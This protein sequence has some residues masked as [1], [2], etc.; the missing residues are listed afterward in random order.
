MTWNPDSMLANADW[1]KR[2]ADFFPTVF[3][4]RTKHMGPGDHPSGSPQDVHGGGGGNET[5]AELIDRELNRIERQKP[6]K[7]I[8]DTWIEMS[9]DQDALDLPGSMPKVSL[10]NNPNVQLDIDIGYLRPG[11]IGTLKA[12]QQQLVDMLEEADQHD[13]SDL[14]RIYL[15]MKKKPH[16]HRKYGGYNVDERVIDIRIDALHEMPRTKNGFHA[17]SHHE[18]TITH[19]IGHLLHDTVIRK[20]IPGQNLK[21]VR[22]DWDDMFEDSLVGPESRRKTAAKVSGYATTEPIEFVAET[23]AGV[24]SGKIYS[25][26][27]LS[28]YRYLDGP[29][30]PKPKE[31]WEF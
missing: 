5:P 13:L 28:L 12:T 20:E 19:E 29:P 10:P 7:K 18:A 14:H 25:E 21:S 4:R 11:G 1:P 8:T 31:W 9:E 23:F 30:L 26:D 24:R 16:P 15:G 27:V 22:A 17:D 3:E 2:T 6:Y